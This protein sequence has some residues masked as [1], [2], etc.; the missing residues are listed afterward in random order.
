MRDLLSGERLYVAMY[1]K[2]EA[3]ECLLGKIQ[4][5][6]LAAIGRQ[7]EAAGGELFVTCTDFPDSLAATTF[8][9]A[10]LC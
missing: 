8:P 1:E 7:I 5:L 9:R 2:P 6:F 4:E 3:L 10:P